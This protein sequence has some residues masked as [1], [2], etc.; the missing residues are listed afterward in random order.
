M[1]V[2]FFN[3]YNTR[4]TTPV[5]GLV[6]SLWVYADAPGS[7]KNADGRMSQWT[8]QTGNGN[9]F[10]MG[11]ASRQ[12][13][14]VALGINGLPSLQMVAAQNQVRAANINIDIQT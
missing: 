6:P 1:D 7:I 9:H 8:D 5:A 4:T 12:P 10:T 11:V 3:K 13:T 14:Y 2:Y